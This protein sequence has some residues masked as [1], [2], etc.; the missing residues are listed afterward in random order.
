MVART[1]RLVGGTTG[2]IAANVAGLPIPGDL[3]VAVVAGASSSIPDD[4]EK[5]LHLKHRRITHYPSIQLAVTGALAYLAVYFHAAPV[6][7]C[8]AVTAAVA[9]ACLMHS[10]ADAMTI[11]PRGI[12]LL[13]PISR[14]GFHLLPHSLRV[15]VDSKSTSEKVFFVV[16]SAIVLSFLYARFRHQISA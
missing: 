11:D 8:L 3:M 7:I 16:W 5:L 9:L 15:R 4:L 6:G 12:A 10:C 14:R 1:H 13:W 2:F